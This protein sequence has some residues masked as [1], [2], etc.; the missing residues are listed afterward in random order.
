M[1]Q[2]MD[3]QQ[4]ATVYSTNNNQ[5]PMIKHNVKEYTYMCITE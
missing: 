1:I 3:K 4:D 2:G 5:Y